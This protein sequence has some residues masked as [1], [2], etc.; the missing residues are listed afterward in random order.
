MN[1]RDL[2][3]GVCVVLIGGSPFMS[4]CQGPASRES[5]P[6]VGERAAIEPA[7]GGAEAGCAMCIYH[8]PGVNECVLAVK[9]DGRAYLVKGS[10]IDDHGDAHAAD[11]LCNTARDAR[12]KGR[13]EGEQFLAEEFDVVR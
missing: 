1:R 13:V 8:M 10:S 11:G 3:C 2:T 7:G 12:V 6:T 9:L 4:A 5:S